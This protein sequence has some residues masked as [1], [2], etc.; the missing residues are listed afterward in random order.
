MTSAPKS[1][2]SLVAYAADT[3]LPHSMTRTPAK[4]CSDISHRVGGRLYH[5]K[6]RLPTR[7]WPEP[8]AARRRRRS[9]SR[10]LASE[11]MLLRSRPERPNASGPAEPWA[12]ARP[13]E[14]LDNWPR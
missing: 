13:R 8:A 10:T 1:A 4:A 6:R 14:L 11:S 3:R 9:V 5:E 12:E 2:I 7:A